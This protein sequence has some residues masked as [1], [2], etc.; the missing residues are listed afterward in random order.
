MAKNNTCQFV[1]YGYAFACEERRSDCLYEDSAV[2]NTSDRQNNSKA[3]IAKGRD[4]I[5]PTAPGPSNELG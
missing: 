3:S 5:S 1:I 4:A 2:E